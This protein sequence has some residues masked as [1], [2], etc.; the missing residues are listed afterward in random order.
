[1]QEL[2]LEGDSSSLYYMARALM[3]MQSRFGAFASIKGVG[4]NAQAVASMLQRMRTEQ[5]DDAPLVCVSPDLH[6]VLTMVN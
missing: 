6:D 4:S 5:G 3:R 2:T 1:M